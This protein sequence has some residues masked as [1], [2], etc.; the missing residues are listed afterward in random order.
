[1]S[2]TLR[3]YNRIIKKAHRYTLGLFDRAVH[4]YGFA[5]HPYRALCMGHCGSCKNPELDQKHQ[6][7]IRKQEFRRALSMELA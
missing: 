2:R 5:F 7:K 6:R 1:M 3:I 4:K